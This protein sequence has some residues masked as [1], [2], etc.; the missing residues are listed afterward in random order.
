M[1][2]I[3]PP[4]VGGIKVYTENIPNG[5][6]LIDL[7]VLYAGD[8]QIKMEFKRIVAGVKDIQVNWLKITEIL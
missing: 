1:N 2:V 7:E 5:E 6:I 3:K 4:R 8:A